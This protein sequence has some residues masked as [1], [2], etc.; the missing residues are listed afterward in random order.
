M[1]N[2]SQSPYQ[3]KTLHC[4]YLYVE[5]AEGQICQEKLLTI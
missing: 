4:F 2:T 5:N 3:N 1:S